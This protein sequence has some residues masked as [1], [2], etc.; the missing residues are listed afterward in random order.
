MSAGRAA[1]AALGGALVAGHLLPSV[2]AIAPL[3]RGM[4]PALCGRSAADHVALTFDDGPHDE[5]TPKLLETL[6]ALDVRATFFVLGG[7]LA[8]HPDVVIRMHGD[9]HEVAVHGW[10]HRP[11]LLRTAA[12]IWTDMRRATR[13]VRELTGEPPLW[14]RPPHGIPTGASLAAAQALGLR[15]VLWTDDGRDWRADATPGSIRRRLGA[16]VGSGAVVLLHDSDLTCAYG[17]WRPVLEVLPDLVADWR[18]RGW[19]VGPLRD[20][21]LDGFAPGP[22]AGVERGTGTGVGRGVDH[23]HAPR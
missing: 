13:A 19:T 4:F 6:D 12:G 17:S 7:Q 5:A 2:A 22:G 21:G 20:H 23:G 3:T 9:G 15:P 11:H 14:W 18:A 1:A 8:R 16:R 10:T